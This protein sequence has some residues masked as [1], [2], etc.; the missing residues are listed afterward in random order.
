[1][2]VMATAPAVPARNDTPRLCQEVHPVS[3]P[4]PRLVCFLALSAALA[5][6]GA[7]PAGFLLSAPDLASGRHPN[8]DSALPAPVTEIAALATGEPAALRGP[9][10]HAEPPGAPFSP[11]APVF[12]IFARPDEFGAFGD[13]PAAGGRGGGGSGGPPFPAGASVPGAF[14]VR[15][16]VAPNT[17]PSDAAAPAPPTLAL[18][19]AGL[20]VLAL[21]RR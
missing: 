4:H 19:A 20:A 2:E 1:M 14:T 13:W 17:S 10:E 16:F 5:L 15:H 7:A 3:P 6:A 18:A 8:F 9:L 21:R 12:D 11:T